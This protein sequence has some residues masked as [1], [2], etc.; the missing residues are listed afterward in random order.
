VLITIC[1]FLGTVGDNDIRGSRRAGTE[2]T[3]YQR[4]VHAAVA[5]E[6]RLHATASLETF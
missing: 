4:F 1:F 3:V 2:K 5:D 6:S